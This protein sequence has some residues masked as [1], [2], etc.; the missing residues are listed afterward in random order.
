MR[1]LDEYLIE[2]ESREFQLKKE[3]IVMPDIAYKP[4]GDRLDDLYN[5][6]GQN[7]RVQLPA[8]FDMR[9]N[10]D[11]IGIINQFAGFVAN[12]EKLNEMDRIKWGTATVD[13][14]LAGMNTERDI[15]LNDPEYIRQ[16]ASVPVQTTFDVV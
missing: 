9:R 8:L 13:F 10:S 11:P 16:V 2:A 7:F 15:L 3:L 6:V 12:T 1:G 5:Q 4:F 14:A